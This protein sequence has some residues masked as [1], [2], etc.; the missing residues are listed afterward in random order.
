MYFF[1]LLL[2]LYL[3]LHLLV[4]EWKLVYITHTHN[5][6]RYDYEHGFVV[7]FI[8]FF[9]PL[10]R[11]YRIS[12]LFPDYNGEILFYSL[13]ILT[14]QTTIMHVKVTYIHTI[15]G[16]FFL[17]Q[18]EWQQ[19]QQQQRYQTCQP[20]RFKKLKKTVFKSPTVTDVRSPMV[21]HRWFVI[22]HVLS[23]IF[24]L[25]Y[26]SC[27]RSPISEWQASCEQVFI[28]KSPPK[29]RFRKGP[30]QKAVL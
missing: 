16:V 10:S 15:L 11:Q 26:F 19:Q 1:L 21:N 2:F 24:H 5:E 9:F 30:L 12:P 25:W 4:G 27:D 28:T 20:S 14:Q 7:A 18:F 8:S 17:L 3:W 13:Y 6:R 29:G 22:C 23:V